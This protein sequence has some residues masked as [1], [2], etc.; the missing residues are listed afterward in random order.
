MRNQK[1]EATVLSAAM[2]KVRSRASSGG[3]EGGCVDASSQSVTGTHGRDTR[4]TLSQHQ[5]GF[6]TSNARVTAPVWDPSGAE[7]PPP[8]QAVG[9]GRGIFTFNCQYPVSALQK[10]K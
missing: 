3:G 4:L 7:S 8:Q 6:P 5:V 1:E 2:L 10:G 9:D